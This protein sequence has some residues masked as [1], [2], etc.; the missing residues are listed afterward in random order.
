MNYHKYLN[1]ISQKLCM[2]NL[3]NPFRA[4]LEGNL[5]SFKLILAENESK[6]TLYP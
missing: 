6:I 3:F 4:D 1:K 2:I 5:L